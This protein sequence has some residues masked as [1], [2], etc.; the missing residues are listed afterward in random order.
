E[1]DIPIDAALFTLEPPADAT[2]VD[3]RIDPELRDVIDEAMEAVKTLPLHEIG[4]AAPILV[5]EGRRFDRWREWEG[6]RQ[7]RVGHREEYS[8]GRVTGGTPREEWVYW[9]RRY[10]YVH[11]QDHYRNSFFTIRAHQWLRHLKDGRPGGW[12]ADAPSEVIRDE[13]D[14]RRSA[15]I[16]GYFTLP[17]AERSKEVLTLD[18]DAKRLTERELYVW[19]DDEW[20]LA[21][22]IQFDYPDELPDRIFEFQ[23]PPGVKIDDLRKR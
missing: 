3:C 22:R 15:R 1:Y 16:V 14:G 9:V 2:I 4:E 18:L 6:W 17:P 12:P 20:R 11:D 19:M 21:M 5:N 10:A 23:P 13:K 7:N 8:D